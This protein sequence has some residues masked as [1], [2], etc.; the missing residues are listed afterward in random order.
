MK[1][2]V[3][4]TVLTLGGT[5]YAADGVAV[6][7]PETVT[8]EDLASGDAAR[9]PPP[10]P[11]RAECAERAR[12]VFRECREQGGS[13]EECETLARHA[14]QGCLERCRERRDPCR[15]HC[16]DLAAHALERCLAHGGSPERCRELAGDVAQGCLH[17]CQAA[18]PCLEGCEARAQEGL[19]RCLEAGG[20]PETC[21][22][23]ARHLFGECVEHC[24]EHCPPPPCRPPLCVERCRELGHALIQRCLANGGTREECAVHSRETV[25]RC[26]AERCAPDRGG[27]EVEGP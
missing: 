8:L 22:E 4:A 18:P 16:R 19:K 12:H 9:C 21:R 25:E 11:C 23:R 27:S 2:L 3:L 6:A 1:A 7:V 13:E 15:V 14:A 26:V 20:D 24:R 5:A 17:R 10:D